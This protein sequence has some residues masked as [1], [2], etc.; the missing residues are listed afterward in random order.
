[1]L[2]STKSES[3]Q[4]A[5]IGSCQ[6]SFMQSIQAHKQKVNHYILQAQLAMVRLSDQALQKDNEQ[7]NT[8]R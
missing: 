2:K 5:L 8:V 7:Y 6:Q 1:M 3:L 4:D